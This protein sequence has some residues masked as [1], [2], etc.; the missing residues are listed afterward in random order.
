M[1]IRQLLARIRV[2]EY[3]T[4][5]EVALLLRYDVETI[6]RK[7]SRGDIPGAVK[8]GRTYRFLKVAVL[9]E[10]NRREPGLTDASRR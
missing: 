10:M 2:E 3:L 9:Q 8:H 4:A 7:A 5:D 1:T 6:R